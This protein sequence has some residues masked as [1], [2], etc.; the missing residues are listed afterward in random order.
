MSEKSRVKVRVKGKPES[1]RLTVTVNEPG[2]K[3]ATMVIT[4]SGYFNHQSGEPMSEAGWT[5]M[6]LAL[7]KVHK[8]I[9]AHARTAWRLKKGFEALGS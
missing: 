3:A 7:D 5:E 4:D 1:G 8:T 9:A 6:V 2:R